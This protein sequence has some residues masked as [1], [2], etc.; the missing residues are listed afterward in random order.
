MGGGI[1]AYCDLYEPYYRGRYESI[2]YRSRGKARR[3]EVFTSV[4]LTWC[5]PRTVCVSKINDH[6]WEGRYSPVWPDGK[7]RPRNVYA[8][9][10][11]ECEEK[12][13]RL[14]REMNGEIAA[15]R[16]GDSTDYPDDVNPKKKAIAAY[17]R[18]NPGVTN[19][20]QI[21]RELHMSRPTVQR[22]YDEVRAELL[23]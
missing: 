22:Y 5:S 4:R 1:D 15:L 13:A 2:D 8:S 21:A 19:K 11:E 14:I 3:A 12:L 6:L 23:K 9:T 17:L 18:E 20:S 16:S 7:K 10:Q